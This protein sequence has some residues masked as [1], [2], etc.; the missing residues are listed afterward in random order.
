[1]VTSVTVRCCSCRLAPNLQW[2]FISTHTVQWVWPVKN[3]GLL[4]VCPPSS[5]PVAVECSCSPTAFPGALRYQCKMDPGEQPRVV[6]DTVLHSDQCSR[7]SEGDQWDKDKIWTSLM[8]TSQLCLSSCC[9]L[10][11]LGRPRAKVEHSYIAPTLT[12]RSQQEYSNYLWWLYRKREGKQ[13][14]QNHQST[15]ETL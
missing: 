3:W 10:T 7:R 9:A 15:Q 1:M 13:L 4:A 12:S 5:A 14:R 6:S 11:K 8:P 2:S